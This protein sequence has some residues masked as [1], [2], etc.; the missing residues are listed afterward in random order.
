MF[1]VNDTVHSGCLKSMMVKQTKNIPYL[2]IVNKMLCL[3]FMLNVFFLPFF[4]K[5]RKINIVLFIKYLFQ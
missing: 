4:K 1:F 3:K 5:V 2:Y